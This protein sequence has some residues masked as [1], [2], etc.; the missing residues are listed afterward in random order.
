MTDGS[1]EPAGAWGGA[2]FRVNVQAAGRELALED[3][4]YLNRMT[5]VGQVLPNVAHELNN[6]LQIIGGMAEMLSL[7]AD[8]P[9]EVRDKILRIVSHSGRAT[10]LMRDLVV[11]AKRDDGGV[12]VVDV[13]KLVE[14]ALSLRRY[15]LARARIAVT[16]EGGTDSRVLARADG[17]YLE[18]VL[19]NLIINAEHSLAGLEGPQIGIRILEGPAGVEVCV[20]DNGP[21]VPE[22]VRSQVTAPFFTTRAPAAGLGLTVAAE[23]MRAQGGRLVLEPAGDAGTTARLTIPGGTQV[24]P[25][26]RA[27]T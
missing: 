3:L 5:T 20:T 25:A 22:H 2:G 8:L 6:A 16:V 19:L 21:G 1:G 10:Q 13:R 26:D 12:A 15:H 27:R 17:H 24:S 7:R 11:F 14:R 4:V 23:L 18:Q 9:Q